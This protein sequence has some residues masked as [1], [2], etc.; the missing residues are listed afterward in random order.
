MAEAGTK[1][2]PVISA[3]GLAR[4]EEE[5]NHLKVVKR[6]EIAEQIKTAIS[7][8]DLSENAEYDEAKNEQAR[9]EGQISQ[10]ENMIR[11]AIVID[12]SEVSTDE[13]N[14]GCVVRVKDIDAGREMEYAI[15]GATEADPISGKISN[16]SPVGAALMGAKKD[17][18]ISFAIPD[19]IRTLKILEIRR[20]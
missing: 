11:N 12:G 19:G 8:G 5:L 13:V 14:V 7:F 9:I 2:R 18:E 17:A 10:L 4:L 3:D 1:G 15:V 20:D 16:E 6:K